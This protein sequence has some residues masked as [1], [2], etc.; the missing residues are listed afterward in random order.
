MCHLNV[1]S[2]LIVAVA[3]A[4]LPRPTQASLPVPYA[5]VGCVHEGKFHS[6][7][8]AG[9]NLANPG[10]R[11]LEGKTIRIQ[12]WLS[13][14]DRFGAQALYIVHEQCR[15]D[16]HRSYFLCNPCQTLPDGPPSRM[17]PNEESGTKVPLPPAAI[18]ELDDYPR[19]MRR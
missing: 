2:W 8:S 7:G 15:E 5:I 4:G 16:L 12:G 19:L 18:R 14:G 6:Q 11:A 3:I 9:P 1:I 13:P 10:I 17:L